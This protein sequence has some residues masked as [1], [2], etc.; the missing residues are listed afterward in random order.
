MSDFGLNVSLYSLMRK[1]SDLIDKV[2]FDLQSGKGVIDSQIRK[3]LAEFLAKL[4]DKENM[5]FD[6]KLISTI[7]TRNL[8]WNENS[9]VVFKN[10]SEM[11]RK[12]QAYPNE[13]AQLEDIAEILDSECIQSLSRIRGI[14]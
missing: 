14:R 10:L 4:S 3:E 13:I 5:E 12:R 9:G 7:L 8:G 2:L 1:Y 11:L 6:V